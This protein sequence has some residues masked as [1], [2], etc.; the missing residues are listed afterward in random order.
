V[1]AAP[2]E[3]TQQWWADALARDPSDEGD[4]PATAHAEVR[5]RFL[6]GAP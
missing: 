6:E 4:E 2:R 1:T 5:G 3:D